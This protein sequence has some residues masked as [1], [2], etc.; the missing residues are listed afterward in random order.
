MSNSNALQRQEQL[1]GLRSLLSWLSKH[2]DQPIPYW[3]TS[4]HRIRCEDDAAVVAARKQ[5]GSCSKVFTDTEVGFEHDFGG[6]ITV[7]AVV[8]RQAVCERV[9]VG[10]R[11]VPAVSYPARDEPVYEYKCPESLLVALGEGANGK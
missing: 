1:T 10:T 4:E 11:T 8:E 9:Q 6:G 3:L 5:L 2:P 7:R